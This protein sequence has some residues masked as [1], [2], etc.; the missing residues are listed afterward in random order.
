[1]RAFGSGENNS[2]RFALACVFICVLTAQD[3]T[4]YSEFTRVDPFGKPVPA[5]TGTRT[6]REILSPALPRN[7]VSSFHVVVEARPG[8]SYTLQVAQNPE[9]AVRVAAYRERYSKIGDH[10]IP[11]ALEPVKLP[12]DTR[13]ETGDIPGQTAQAFWVDL[14]VDRSAAVRRIKVEPQAYV[15]ERWIRYPME[16]RIVRTALGSAP[17]PVVRGAES[18]EAPS[19]GSALAA[20]VQSWCTGANRRTEGGAAAAPPTVRDFIARNA[21]QDVG[22]SAG[23]APPVLL[24]LAGVPDRAA[25]CRAFKPVGADAEEYLAVRDAV[26]GARE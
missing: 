10:W 15:D 5:D 20:W 8:Q 23:V 6:P 22:F 14:F 13:M 19:S 3:L 17:L 18:I 1:L 4:V 26:I 2:V 21:A 12:I 7:A 25:L 24:R 11:D 9:N 16:A